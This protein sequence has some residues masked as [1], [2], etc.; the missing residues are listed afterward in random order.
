VSSYATS[1]EVWAAG[2][3]FVRVG[4]LIMLIPGLGE[5]YVPVRL[6]LTL[7][8]LL[9]FCL[10]PIAMPTLPPVPAAID[11]LAGAIIKEALIGL[12]I[13]GLIRLF[14]AALTTAGEIVSIQTTLAFA[15][16][17]NPTQAQPTTSVSTF[18]MLVGLVLV[19]DTDLHRM[20]IAAIAHSYTLFAPTRAIPLGDAATLAA[21]TVGKT[22]AL[23]LQLAAPVVVFSLVFNLAAG[24]IG[25]AMPQFQI[26]FVVAPLSV[27]LGLSIFALSLGTI[28]LVWLDAYNTFVKQFT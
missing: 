5:S 19:F 7:A 9:T 28:G 13:G 16:T 24:L 10:L 17:A 6:R 11:G 12:M 15:Q 22:F 2:L 27:L 26:F 21:Q 20:F 23:G 4:A 8:L 25:R 18:L 14:V 3:V 1:A